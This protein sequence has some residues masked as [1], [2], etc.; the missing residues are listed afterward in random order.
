MQATLFG[1]MP[2]GT[3]I[4]C[5]TLKNIEA[6]V[7][8]LTLGA[9]IADFL[10]GGQSIVCGFSTLEDYLADDSYQGAL[11]GRVANRV[12]NASFTLNETRY[13]LFANDGK[14]SLHGGKCGFNRRLFNVLNATDEAITLTRISPDGE[15]GYPGNLSLKVTYSLS[16]TALTIDYT[17]TSDAD[18][19]INLTN[20]S[21]FNLTGLGSS[22]MDYEAKICADF[23]TEVDGELIPTGNRPSVEGTPYDLRTPRRIGEKPNGFDNNFRLQKIGEDNAP[24]LAAVVRGGD[25]SLSVYTTMS[26]L[27]FYTGCVLAGEPPFRGGIPKA[28]YT[29]FCLETQ[30]EPDGPNRGTCLLRAGEVYRHTTVYRVEPLA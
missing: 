12:A 24:T 4:L 22:I 2:D 1:R 23:Y 6:E 28:P 13:S 25:L 17:A 8:I 11:I 30:T 20:H 26:D 3:E 29:A 5:Y 10:V 15:E 21:Y 9:T 18:T 19:P 7:R 16:G 27:Q 14:H